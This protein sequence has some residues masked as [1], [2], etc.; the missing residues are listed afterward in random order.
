MIGSQ[1]LAYGYARSLDMPF[2]EVVE[3]AREALKAQG[4][5]VL[6]EIDIKE[7]LRE[8]LGVEFRNYKILGVCNPPLAYEALQ[9]ELNLG[10]LLPC[11]VVVY[12]EGGRTVAAAV[13]A[14]KMM[15]VTGNPALA[16]TAEKANELLKRAIDAIGA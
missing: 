1:T 11:N 6:C 15:E 4:F 16:P 3:R 12:E 10:L 2:D 9:Q 8:K 7:K 14:A 13:D 5:G